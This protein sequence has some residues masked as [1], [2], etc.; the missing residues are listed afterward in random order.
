M[1]SPA[2]VVSDD[3][4]RWRE[5]QDRGLQGDRRRAVAMKWMMALIAIMLGAMIGGL[6]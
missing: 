1:S 3:L 5:W 2:L 6:L 4:Q